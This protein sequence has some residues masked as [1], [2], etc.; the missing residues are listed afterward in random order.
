[1]KRT[2][3]FIITI[4]VVALAVIFSWLYFKYFKTDN[5]NFLT[6]PVTRGDIIETVK[7]RGEAVAQKEFNL[8]FY[9]GGTVAAI[10]VVDGEEVKEGDQLIKLDVASYE[11]EVKKLSAVLAQ[12]QSN[13]KKLQAGYTAEDLAVYETKVANAKQTL[14][15]ERLAFRDSLTDAYIKT[16]NAVGAYIEQFFDNP[17]TTWVRLNFF[18]ADSQVKTDLEKNLQTVVNNFTSWQKLLD[19][20]TDENL[21]DSA[22]QAESYLAYVRDFLSKIALAVNSL[23]PNTSLTTADITAYRAD[24]S[25]A[26][27]AINTAATNLIAAEEAL[28]TAESNLALAQS[29]LKSK[30]AGTREE[31]ITEAEAKITEAESDIATVRDKIRKAILVA[32]VDA[33]VMKIPVERGETLSAGETAII[34]AGAKNKIQSDV[35]E[36]DIVKIPESGGAK[37]TISF[38]AF[39]GQKFTGKV[40]SIEPKEIVKDEDKYYRVNLYFESGDIPLRSGMSADLEIAVAEKKNVLLIPEFAVYKKDGDDFVKV[41]EGKKEKEVAVVI[42]LTDGESTEII[43][44]LTEGQT[45]VVS[46]N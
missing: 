8:G 33:R 6:F 44:G 14:A 4:S 32:P 3:Y 46:T 11:L 26:R 34:L 38:D 27:T 20:L 7:V 9:T 39:P 43:S 29:E 30:Q 10:A 17:R 22:N 19:N 41:L 24:V 16:N 2:S 15:D 31:D 36:L 13:L 42:G 28:Q 37:A 45:V 25:T 1:M 40:V 5:S 18:V 23:A 35:S 21:L 12:R